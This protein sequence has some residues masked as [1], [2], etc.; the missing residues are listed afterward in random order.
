VAKR[1]VEEVTCCLFAGFWPIDCIARQEP[2][3]IEKHGRAVVI[4][5]S[6]EDYERLTAANAS[7]QESTEKERQGE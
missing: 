6:I 5:I 1:P 4:V 2:V 7:P 3:K